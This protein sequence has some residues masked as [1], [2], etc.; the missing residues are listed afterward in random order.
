MDESFVLRTKAQGRRLHPKESGTAVTTGDCPSGHC[1]APLSDADREARGGPWVLEDTK[2][3]APGPDTGL[4]SA[5]LREGATSL[6]IHS[7][8]E[9]WHQDLGE[10][11]DPGKRS[12]KG[13]RLGR[14]LRMESCRG[15]GK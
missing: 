8:L 11:R 2:G 15:R 5:E 3:A 14:W 6:P 1:H 7:G 10:A 9:L 4:N 12:G 13:E